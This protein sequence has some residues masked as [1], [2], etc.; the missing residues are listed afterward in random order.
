MILYQQGWAHFG[1]GFQGGLICLFDLL[2]E[3]GQLL[4]YTSP[5]FFHSFYL[6]EDV[7]VWPEGV[8]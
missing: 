6:V 2:V 5:S 4:K 3:K 1:G 8:F 7:Q